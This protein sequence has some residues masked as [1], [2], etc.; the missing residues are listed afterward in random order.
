MWD[1]ILRMQVDA[2]FVEVV[3]FRFVCFLFSSF[4]L[5]PAL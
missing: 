2:E 1:K 3:G 5:N 4:L